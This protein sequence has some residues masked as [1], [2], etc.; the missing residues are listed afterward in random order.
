MKISWHGMKKHLKFVLFGKMLNGEVFV[1]TKV[2][3]AL[4]I[5][6]DRIQTKHLTKQ[7]VT[8][9]HIYLKK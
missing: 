4:K 5:T 3:A 9:R 2:A 7:K 8:A 1:I 6:F